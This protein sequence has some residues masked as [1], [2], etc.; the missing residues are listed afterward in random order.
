MAG[1][2]SRWA[3]AHILVLKLLLPAALRAAQTCRY[4]VYSE[5]D[6][7]VFFE[8]IWHLGGDRCSNCI[9]AAAINAL[10]V[11]STCPGEMYLLKMTL[12]GVV[13]LHTSAAAWLGFLASLHCQWSQ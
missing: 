3:L 10:Q 1:R 5:A 11:S 9:F 2:P 4:L 7:E 6:F 8:E 13:G 12:S